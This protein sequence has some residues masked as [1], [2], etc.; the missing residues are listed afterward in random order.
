[1]PNRDVHRGSHPCR[2]QI[3]L[4]QSCSPPDKG[5][6]V[7]ADLGAPA[8]HPERTGLQSQPDD[9]RGNPRCR[10]RVKAKLFLSVPSDGG[11]F[12]STC[13]A[14]E[15][16]ADVKDCLAPTLAT[17]AI[18]RRPSRCEQSHSGYGT[19]QA[20]WEGTL[21]RA[22]GWEPPT[23]WQGEPMFDSS[24][25]GVQPRVVAASSS[26]N[27]EVET[28]TWLLH[29][30]PHQARAFAL[31]MHELAAWQ[32]DDDRTER[33]RLVLGLLPRN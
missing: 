10:A 30:C 3:R 21:G 20:H 9:A 22:P 1:L 25:S 29:W 32:Y 14:H 16:A 4:R 28:V 19:L 17:V 15:L 2:G 31:A 26:I 33:W 7:P 5:F 12:W 13:P 24:P 11:P 8:R 27:G 6:Q 18:R 23:Y